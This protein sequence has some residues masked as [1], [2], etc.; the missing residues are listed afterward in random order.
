MRNELTTVRR[1]AVAIALALFAVFAFHPAC[2]P[3]SAHHG[4]FT[5]G[6]SGEFCHHGDTHHL[7]AAV[8]TQAAV[9][10][11]TTASL[12]APDAD[13]AALPRPATTVQLCP[14]RAEHTRSG[15][16]LL[17]DLGISRT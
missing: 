10:A 12:T 4:A 7:S 15:R 5:P 17:H 1:T 3:E 13:V 16:T 6:I 9:Q 14:W 11:N 2:P 8:P